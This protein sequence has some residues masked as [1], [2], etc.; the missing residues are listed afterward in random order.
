MAEVK[1]DLIKNLEEE[2]PSD[3]SMAS[4]HISEDDDEDNILEESQP[5]YDD[6]FD[7]EKYLR[8]FQE[9]VEASSN[10]KKS[11]EKDKV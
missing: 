6:D 7:V 4:V 9:R 8:K 2:F 5:P 10:S 3:T 11:K 1:R